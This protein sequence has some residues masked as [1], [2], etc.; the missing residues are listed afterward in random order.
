MTSFICFENADKLATTLQLSKLYAF[1][2]VD[3]LK[4]PAISLQDL[5]LHILLAQSDGWQGP[6]IPPWPFCPPYDLGLA[7]VDCRVSVR[8]SQHKNTFVLHTPGDRYLLH[9][10]NTPLPTHPP[11]TLLLISEQLNSAVV[12]FPFATL[13]QW[14]ETALQQRLL[15][16]VPFIWNSR[17][18]REALFNG[19]TEPKTCL[20]STFF[21]FHLG[22]YVVND[23]GPS[24]ALYDLLKLKPLFFRLARI[25]C[26]YLQPDTESAVI[27]GEQAQ[28]S[29][30]HFFP[31]LSAFENHVQ[32]HGLAVLSLWGA[33]VEPNLSQNTIK[34]LQGKEFQS[35]DRNDRFRTSALR[36]RIVIGVGV[37]GGTRQALNLDEV[38][39][40]IVKTFHPHEYADICLVIDG[41][42]AKKVDN[43]AGSSKL[44]SVEAEHLIVAS[45]LS[46]LDSLGVKIVSVIDEPLESQLNCLMHCHVIIGHTGSSS[47]KYLCLLNKPQLLHSPRGVD[48]RLP[49]QPW[50][51]GI[52]IC[53][54][55]AFRGSEH[56]I[57]LYTPS[58]FVK[59]TEKSDRGGVGR[60]NYRLDP[61]LMAAMFHG[62]YSGL[63]ALQASSPTP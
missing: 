40:A 10:L 2:P 29:L 22:H 27:S 41:L 62:F 14:K 8:L 57:E 44:L 28:N 56:A 61:D 49:K 6:V 53:F 15:E 18:A 19:L 38:I 59:E 30:V 35:S 55:R 51:C 25:N 39:E 21:S 52:G 42:A 58:A 26:G 60:V 16:Q 37:R 7:D 34:L 9:I 33:H 45:I 4:R 17:A 31:S 48:S 43:E 11:L 63:R 1:D 12:T 13:P 46:R 20:I 3:L 54:G 47:A 5:V 24:T 50:L 23:L 36:S 32:Q